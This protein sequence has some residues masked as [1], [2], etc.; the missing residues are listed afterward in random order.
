MT[1][2]HAPR[3]AAEVSST[4]DTIPVRDTH[5]VGVPARARSMAAHVDGCGGPVTVT[6]FQ[7][8]QSNPT[9]RL[10]SPGG[11][12]V[13]RRQPPGKPVPPPPPP[14]P[15]TPAPTVPR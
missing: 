2:D 7:G 1:T 15:A 3:S 11:E 13:L 14:A 5:R 6:Q 10:S 4:S 8:G 9:Y 12:Y